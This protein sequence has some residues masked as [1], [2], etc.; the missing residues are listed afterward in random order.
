[1]K[2]PQLSPAERD[3]AL[4]TVPEWTLREDGRAI[5]RT[6][7]FASFSEAFAFITRVAL[8]AEQQNHHPDWANSYNRVDIAFTT[9][10]AGGLTRR[11][12]AAARAVDHLA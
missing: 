10:A 3:E 8:I 2:E 11:D 7:R 12:I 1:M 4:R 6:F 5:S 9:H